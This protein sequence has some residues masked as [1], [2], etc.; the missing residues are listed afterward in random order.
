MKTATVEPPAPRMPATESEPL[1]GADEQAQR[2]W[3]AEKQQRAAED[4]TAISCVIPVLNEEESLDTLA[5]KLRDAL[6]EIGQPYEVIFVDDGSIDG[7]FNKLAQL[8]TADRRVRVIRLR[9]N[10]GQSAAFSA[11]IDLARGAII[12]TLDADLQNDPADIGKL[13]DKIGEGYDVVSGWRANRQDNFL[14]RQLP[15]RVANAMISALTGVRLHD[16]GCSLKAYRS[17]VIKD[18]PLYG[19]LHRFL[20]ALVSWMGIRVAEVEVGHAPR[21]FG[22]SKY[23]LSR[24]MMVMLDLIAVK[25]L[26]D[27]A[28]RPI[29]IFGLL[30]FL[31]SALGI[32]LGLYL[33]TLKLIFQQPIGDRPLLLLA[34]LLTI[35]GVQFVTMGL[36]GELVIRNRHD[37]YGKRIYSIR[38][39][40]I[41]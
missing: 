40:L 3:L 34:V 7:S 13:L 11:G 41:H 33:S 9:R 38:D 18:V 36:L 8:H 16:Y 17:E 22:R 29:Q 4:P 37:A 14:T 12:V 39:I 2:D 10:F 23:G 32:G 31:C 26:L 30:G 15:S 20:P 25:F 27:Y 21:K 24:V 28:T 1:I 19:Q 5:A 6:G 35:L